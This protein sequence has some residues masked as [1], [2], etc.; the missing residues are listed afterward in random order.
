MKNIFACWTAAAVAVAETPG[1]GSVVTGF[2]LVLLSI[3]SRW[4]VSI[5]SVAAR[6]GPRE[7]G[8]TVAPA[9]M[10]MEAPGAIT[11]LSKA[12]APER[13]TGLIVSRLVAS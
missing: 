13:N 2:A 3:S 10:P 8:V 12:A 11:V 1:E 6:L 5:L 7:Y 4:A 9:G